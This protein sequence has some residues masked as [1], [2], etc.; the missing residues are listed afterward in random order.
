MLLLQ[1]IVS[2]IPAALAWNTFV[3]PHVDGADD[4]PAL[5]S[6]LDSG[7]YNTNATILFEKGVYYNIWTP[8]VFPVF[9]NVEVKVEGNLSYPEDIPAIQ[10]S[11][12]ALSQTC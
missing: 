6:A 5:T 4:T 10:C 2:L 3:V 9:K 8:I 7:N 12:T 11:S 1:V